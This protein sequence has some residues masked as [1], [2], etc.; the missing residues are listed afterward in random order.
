M[1]NDIRPLQIGSCCWTPA[2]N[3]KRSIFRRI[4]DPFGVDENSSRLL[5]V[6]R[7]HLWLMIFV[8][9]RSEAAAGR[10]HQ[11][12]REVFSVGYSTPSGSTKILLGCCVS[13]GFTYG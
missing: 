4:F 2:S 7:F 11:I 10:R 12:R 3:S 13:V 6:R 5:R 9:Y 8:P 1:A